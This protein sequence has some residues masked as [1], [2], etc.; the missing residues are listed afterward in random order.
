[1]APKTK[2][3]T[4]ADIERKVLAAIDAGLS[5]EDIATRF[6]MSTKTIS[7]IKKRINGFQE[8]VE[9][10]KDIV[11]KA[12]PDKPSRREKAENDNAALQLEIAN[13]ALGK[14]LALAK[15]ID[16]DKMPEGNKAVSM[17]ILIDKARLITGQASSI[18]E[19]RD[20]QIVALGLLDK[21][22]K[23]SKGKAPKETIIDVKAEPVAQLAEDT[24]DENPCKP[25]AALQPEK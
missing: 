1:M 23:E 24:P 20:V 10:Q 22:L 9:P 7:R 21:R 6:S 15:S 14:A 8:S 12:G 18:S 17:G 11:R 2:E 4:S 25:D 5:Y 13:T 3:R 16:P 19:H